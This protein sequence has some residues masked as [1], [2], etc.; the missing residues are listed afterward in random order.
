MSSVRNP[1]SD[2]GRVAPV[3]SAERLEHPVLDR[4]LETCGHH[5]SSDAV[6]GVE[7]GPEVRHQ[8]DRR[9]R[10]RDVVVDRQL[11]DANQP[12]EAL[13]AQAF[14]VARHH[15]QLVEVLP[16]GVGR[17]DR[18]DGAGPLRHR[19]QE[20]PVDGHVADLGDRTLGCDERCRLT[21]E[22]ADQLC[23]VERTDGTEIVHHRCIGHVVDLDRRST[24]VIEG[25]DVGVRR[26]VDDDRRSGTIGERDHTRR[27]EHRSPVDRPGQ[28][29]ERRDDGG[30]LGH[31]RDRTAK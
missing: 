22:A 1:S 13:I 27:C 18:C 29:R 17:R 15:E 26:R 24:D 6:Q 23:L 7:L 8:L 12:A 11:D 21:V 2:A 30:I 19:R 9:R 20:C 25:L 4:Q 28:R 14:L 10:I 5:R 3:V 16:A 31:Q